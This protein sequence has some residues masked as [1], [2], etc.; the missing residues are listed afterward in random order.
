MNE[1]LRSNLYF[2]FT[3][4]IPEIV[5]SLMSLINNNLQA[6]KPASSS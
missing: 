6:L 1:K 4:T 3:V 2:I 5:V